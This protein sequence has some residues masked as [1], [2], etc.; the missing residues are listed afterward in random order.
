MIDIS[1][2]TNMFL[3]DPINAAVQELDMLFNTE[4]TELIGYP[5]YGTN[6]WQYLW[7]LTPLE[8]DLKQY[9]TEKIRETYYVKEFDPVVEVQHINGTEN[10]IYYIKISLHDKQGNEITIQ[11]YELK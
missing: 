1:L 2:D 7:E 8:T 6:W 10:S 9:I 5:T 3:T 4:N 11:Q